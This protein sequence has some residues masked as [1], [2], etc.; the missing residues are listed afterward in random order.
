MEEANK[1]PPEDRTVFARDGAETEREE[2]ERL[3]HEEREDQRMIRRLKVLS[4]RVQEMI[5]K[6]DVDGLFK[7]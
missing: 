5:T 2:L 4:E 6:L 3:R 1:T 7:D